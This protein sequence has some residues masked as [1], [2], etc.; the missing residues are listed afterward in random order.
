MK[1]FNKKHW[2]VRHDSSTDNLERLFFAKDICQLM[3]KLNWETLII[4]CT[5]KINRYFMS[6]CIIFEVT[7]LNIS[8]YVLFVFLSSEHLVDYEWILIKLIELY[9]MLS[10]LARV[11]HRARCRWS[12]MS[13]FEKCSHLAIYIKRKKWVIVHE[14][15]ENKTEKTEKWER[16]NRV[17]ATHVDVEKKI[18]TRS[19]SII[20]ETRSDSIIIEI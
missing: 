2:F 7:T 1:L 12:C 3:T 5:Y 18:E 13:V 15:L 20:I 9:E 19:D 11:V 6:L 16:Y 8:F 17:R 10:N 14:H 4:D